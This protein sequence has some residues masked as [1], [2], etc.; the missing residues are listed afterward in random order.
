MVEHEVDEHPRDGDVKPEGERDAGD[1]SVFVE[2]L[3]E[4][5]DDR[6]ER[7][8]GD[9][10]GEDAVGDEDGKIK[11]TDSARALE[12]NGTHESVIRQIREQKEDRCDE[13]GDHQAPMFL[14]VST[15]DGSEAEEE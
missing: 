6:D 2:A 11:E 5:P 9:D 13:S 3:P 7:Q 8:R 14:P 4:R 15:A 1:G 10:G 12:S